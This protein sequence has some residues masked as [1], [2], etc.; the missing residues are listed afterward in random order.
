MS[1][2]S[3]PLTG[4]GFK[5]TKL[6][7]TDAAMCDCIVSSDRPQN[8][9]ADLYECQQTKHQRKF[10]LQVHQN[11]LH[12]PLLL[13]SQM[14]SK[15]F[16]RCSIVSLLEL[17]TCHGNPFTSHEISDETLT[18]LVSD[19]MYLNSRFLTKVLTCCRI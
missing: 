13:K 8:A 6:M 9:H 14:N 2:D 1:V 12:L 4:T 15:T 5:A 16:T 7:H 18:S 10:C 11:H 19:F 17:S 3:L